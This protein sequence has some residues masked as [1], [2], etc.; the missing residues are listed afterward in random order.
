MIGFVRMTAFALALCF[1]QSAAQADTL[2]PAPDSKVLAQQLADLLDPVDFVVAMDRRFAVQRLES[3]TPTNPLSEIRQKNPKLF[4]L[5]EATWQDAVESVIRKHYPEKR[6]SIAGLF[7]ASISPDDLKT[8][9]DYYE[10][11]LG[12]KVVAIGFAKMNLPATAAPTT[13]TKGEFDA[14]ATDARLAMVGQ[15]SDDEIATMRKFALSPTV[16]RFEPVNHQRMKIG[17]DWSNGLSPKLQRVVN[18]RIQ[19]A[20]Q[21]YAAKH[22]HD[23]R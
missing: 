19:K 6:A 20:M 15:L 13:M 9:V 17:L 12:R 1:V 22:P 4:A 8:L 5:V 16:T 14:A 18:E 23:P 10:S 2:V 3:L 7:Q 11:P 21:D